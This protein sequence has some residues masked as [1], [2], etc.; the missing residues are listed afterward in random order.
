MFKTFEKFENFED[1]RKRVFKI[2]TILRV[3]R[4]IFD[5]FKILIKNL[6]EFKKFENCHKIYSLMAKLAVIIDFFIFCGRKHAKNMA[7]GGTRTHIS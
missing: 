1:F 5:N 2:S 6:G 7:V 3:S 4:F